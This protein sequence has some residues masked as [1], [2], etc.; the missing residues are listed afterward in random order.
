[1][2][3][4]HLLACALLPALPLAAQTTFSGLVYGTVTVQGAPFDLLLDLVVPAGSGPWPLVVWVHGGGWANGSRLPIPGAVTRLLP[5]GYAVA[6][7]DY[8]LSGQAVWPAQIQDCKAAIRFLRANAGT[9]GLD[10]NRI[11][12]MGSSA[13]GHLVAALATMGDVGV[14]RS[15]SFVVNLEG[16][17]GPFV[18]TSSRVQAAVD[19]FG[20]MNMLLANDFPGF[21]HD[22]ANSPESRLLGGPIQL[23]PEQWATVDPVSFLTADDPPLLIMHGTDD[24]TVPFQ[25]SEQLLAAAAAIGHPV[26]MFA[27]QDNGHG[28]PGFSAP[29]AVAAIDAF[30]DRTLRNLP[31]TTVRITAVDALAAESGDPATFAIQR[32]GSTAAALT[33]PIALRGALSVAVDCDPVPLQVTMPA[34]AAQ[35][36][37][38]LQPRQDQQVE[39]DEPF[40]IHLVPT[41]AFRIDAAAAAAAG[42]VVDDDASA[43]LPVVTVQPLDALATEAPG[44]P[45]SLRLVR[46]GSTAATL[47]VSYECKGSAKAGSDYMA[48][49][50]SATFAIGSIDHVVTVQPLQDTQ[51]EP[52]ETVVLALQ[53]GSNYAIGSASA[54]HVVLSD[55]D[56]NQPLPVVGVIATDRD[57]GEPSETGAFTLTRTGATTSPLSVALSVG[58]TAAPGSDYQALPAMAVIPA[59]SRWVR[60]PVQVIDD[61]NLEGDED[62]RIEILPAATHVTSLAMRQELWLVDDEAPTPTATTPQLRLGPLPV[63]AT[64]TATLGGGAPNGIGWL[65]VSAAPAYLPV[66]PLGTVRIDPTQGGVFADTLLDSAGAGTLDVVV[67]ATAALAGQ[68]FWWQ[69]IVLVPTPA[70]LQFTDVESRTLLGPAP[71]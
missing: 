69:G 68:R 34:G 49:S 51:R 23:R 9:Y 2:R 42:V 22:A 45:G 7:I 25:Q 29:D 30:L 58:G 53:P 14:T 47:T 43:A 21:D 10:P 4:H 1:M 52:G 12:V 63:G 66:P 38:D 64:G 3:C 41:T 13:G 46:T 6:S 8:R 20:P 56:R 32:S 24:T 17:V 40:A 36:L 37:L 65:L 35:V 18:G 44:D 16:S 48:M 67:P 33:V 71:F 39:G 55:D 57:V 50:G 59:G 54:G 70:V 5:R 60:V 26:K 62:V 31:T 27:V 11:G 61:G 15:G 28:G 19:Q